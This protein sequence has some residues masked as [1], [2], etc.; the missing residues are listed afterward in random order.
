[1]LGYFLLA[2]ACRP[3]GSPAVPWRPSSAHPYQEEVSMNASLERRPLRCCSALAVALL[4]CTPTGA[5]AATGRGCAG[6]WLTFLGGPGTDVAGGVPRPRRCPGLPA[7]ARPRGRGETPPAPP[8]RRPP[9][10]APP[11][12]PRG[13]VFGPP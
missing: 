8:P 2:R 1:M 10:L 11:P 7:G 12:P 6:S 4:C 5:M 9:P 3:R 13:P